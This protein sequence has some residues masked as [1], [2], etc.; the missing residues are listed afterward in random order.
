[1]R[2]APTLRAIPLAVLAALAGCRVAT[3]EPTASSHLCEGSGCAGA[4]A[5]GFADCN[6]D[7]DA[8]GCE[9]DL[10]SAGSCRACGVACEQGQVCSEKG[11]AWPSCAAAGPGRAGCGPG[12][13]EDCCA[14]LAV[15]GGTFLRDDDGVFDTTTQFPATVHAFR[16]D[17]FEVTVG[18]F[19]A[20]LDA[21]AGGWRPATGSGKHAYLSRG[22]LLVQEGGTTHV[23][24]GWNPGWNQRQE[25]SRDEWNLAL[26]CEGDP[27]AT[28][29][30]APGANED[31]P[32]VC[33]DWSSAL[34]FCIWDG[35]FLPTEAE[36]HLAA[37]GGAEQRVRPWSMPPS[38]TAIDDAH[39]VYCGAAGCGRRAEPPGS[40]S[41][42]GDGRWGHADL[43]GNANEWLYDG[44]WDVGDWPVPCVDCA[45]EP[46]ARTQRA[47]AGS[48]FVDTADALRSAR[49]LAIDLSGPLG[50]E[51]AAR[52]LA[53]GDR[54]ARAPR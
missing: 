53:V 5:A 9:A 10:T 4:C 47:T 6:G 37:A 25:W 30:A 46:D 27:R 7:L 44:V 19:R 21:V 49:R 48:G 13:D 17:R 20:F 33:L 11:C 15:P 31:R 22:G 23:E 42:A 1:M 39:A 16:L 41:P 51:L 32:I 29:T 8:D 50:P 2:P 35:G 36:W 52:V 34:A 24:S 14:S 54:C 3:L 12:H 43:V 40:R 18:R 38:S 45:R 28:W 26:S